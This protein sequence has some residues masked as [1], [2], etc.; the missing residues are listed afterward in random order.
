MTDK[1][2]IVTFYTEKYKRFFEAWS[3]SIKKHG[4][5]TIAYPCED[6]G[7]WYLNASNKP[8]VILESLDNVGGK[9]VVWCDIDA[10]MMK[11]PELFDNIETDI[12]GYRINQNQEWV[13]QFV[14]EHYMWKNYDLIYTGTVYFK[15][16]DKTKVLCKDWLKYMT[17][18][19]WLARAT[20]GIKA[21][22]DQDSFNHLVQEVHTNITVTEL[23]E[24]YCYIEHHWMSPKYPP[25]TVFL[26]YVEGTINSKYVGKRINY[27]NV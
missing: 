24:Q 12:A 25:D 7:N 17:S 18:D 16:N 27:A 2:V 4:I 1:F 23:P 5:M 22:G 10:K 13:K 20:S 3:N 26:H 15:N 21:M 8:K 19:E 6:T 11:Y 9:D 14:D